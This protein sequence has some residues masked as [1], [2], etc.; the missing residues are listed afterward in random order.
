MLFRFAEPDAQDGLLACYLGECDYV[1]IAQVR[2]RLSVPIAVS[3]CFVHCCLPHCVIGGLFLL[4]AHR[5]ISCLSLVWRAAFRS[6]S[7]SA[8]T[9]IATSFDLFS[10]R[11]QVLDHL[12]T[13]FQLQ[14]RTL[15]FGAPLFE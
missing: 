2:Y 5:A 7:N 12:M 6:D 1:G 14:D 11:I 15:D 13:C 9:L 3:L 8:L 10:Q 4:A